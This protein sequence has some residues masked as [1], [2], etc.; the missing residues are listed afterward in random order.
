MTILI[1]LAC[2]L[3]TAAQKRPVNTVRP[4]VISPPGGAFEPGEN[5]SVVIRAEPG[6]RII[7]SFTHAFPNYGQGTEVNG[8]VVV[9]SMP[10]SSS[11][12]RAVAVRPGMPVSQPTEARYTRMKSK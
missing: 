7:Y 8:D 9:I 5:V 10:Q 1:L 4:P 6:C 3:L 12:L 2:V 11:R